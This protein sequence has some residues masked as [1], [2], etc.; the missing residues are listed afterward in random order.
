MTLKEELNTFYKTF[1]L[2]DNG[3]VNDK[4]FG[5]PLPFFE[6]HLP[7]FEWRRKK[8]HIHDLEHVLNK[9]D[10]TW[11]GEIFIA[12]WEIATGFWKYFP[13]CIFPL[14]TIGFGLWKHPRSIYRGFM[15]GRNDRGIASLNLRKEELLR[16]SKQ[17]LSELTENKKSYPSIVNNILLLFWIGIGTILFTSPLLLI[18]GIYL[19]F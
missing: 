12:S 7:N 10:T 4:T 18:A 8:I 17:D 3:G 6:I 19:F 1:N 14:W 11:K 5:V 15:K 16:L 2:P 13:V 9:Q